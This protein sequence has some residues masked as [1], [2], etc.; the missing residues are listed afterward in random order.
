M[1]RADMKVEEGKAG[2]ERCREGKAGNERQA[3]KGR[4]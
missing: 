3:R 2:K 4:Q 1:L